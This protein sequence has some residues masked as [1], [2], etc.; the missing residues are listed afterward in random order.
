MTSHDNAS[1]GDLVRRS[2][3]AFVERDRETILDLLAE[4]ATWHVFGSSGLAGTVEGR[5]AVWERFFE[6]MWDSPT[7]PEVH[8]ILDSDEH[9]VVLG[10]V[11]FDLP[12]GEHRFKFVEVYHHE[13]GQLTERWFFTDRRAELDDVL[14]RIT[15]A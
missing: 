1:G 11:V 12:D 9:V 2:Y 15:A 13:D 5:D 4:D 7:T 3:E 14:D 6:P 8:D 10:E